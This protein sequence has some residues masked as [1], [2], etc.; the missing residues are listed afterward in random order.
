MQNET[1]AQSKAYPSIFEDRWERTALII[2]IIEVVVLFLV[3]AIPLPSGVSS[4][5]NSAYQSIRTTVYAQ[6]PFTAAITIFL[7]NFLNATLE[8]I[9]GLGAIWFMISTAATSL[10]VSAIAPAAGYS[11]PILV[12]SLFL[13]PHSWIELPAYA[14]AATEGIYM[15]FA[16][17][18][19][20]AVNYRAELRRFVNVWIVIA[21]ELLVAG[22]FESAEINLLPT[23]PSFILVAWFLFFIL[24][25]P[26][27]IIRR[28]AKKAIK[29]RELAMQQPAPL[30]TGPA[31]P[32][33]QSAV[34]RRGKGIYQGTKKAKSRLKKR[35]TSTSTKRSKSRRAR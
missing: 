20:S 28:N 23:H 12:F 26:V 1:P 24:L 6:D 3:S 17:F 5:L 13:A 31:A 22:S 18:G 2:F 7:H 15:L 30:V 29:E 27:V 11:G 33:P 8:L 9:P 32:Q 35:K 34:Q 21:G 25:I 14:I 10:T 19:L 16:L 4:V